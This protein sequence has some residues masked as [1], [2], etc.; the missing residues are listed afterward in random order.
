[1]FY[2]KVI[3]GRG[4]MKPKYLNNLIED[5]YSIFTR[6]KSGVRTAGL[7]ALLVATVGIGYAGSKSQDDFKKE[8]LL[9]K[10]PISL[11]EK[12]YQQSKIAFGSDRDGN[13]EIYIINSDGTGL[14]RLTNNP[15][16]DYHAS[17]SPDGK[18][19][20]FNS[21]RD[22][23]HEIYV[24]NSD[25]TEQKNLTNNPATDFFPSWSPDGKKIAF[26][27]NRGG[28]F[29]GIYGNSE[30][31]VM[32]SDGTEQKRLTNNPAED[33]FASW[34][35]DG[36]KIAFNSEGDVTKVDFSS[37]E[38]VN[39]EIYVINVDG[40]EQRRL[41]LDGRPSW[42]PDGKKIAFSPF[43]SN[44]D[45]NGEI[46][47]INV[48]GTEQKRLT[49]NPAEDY[50]ASWS[51]DGKKI[52]FWSDRD[53]NDEIYVMNSDGTEQKNLTK[54]P[55]RDFNPFWSP[56]GKK[57]AF[58]SNRD[59][60]FREIYVMNS[61]GSQQ[62]RLTNNPALDTFSSWSPYLPFKLEMQKKK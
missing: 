48:D 53:G 62:T 27:S 59:G 11:E 46:Y 9:P 19:I 44:R 25:G 12:T 17:W 3:I 42:S 45:V 5:S 22:G 6:I 24:M 18:K 2:S 30:I 61:D 60:D 55:A 56:D 37:G 36:K 50:F 1:M 47:V 31:Y 29:R 16:W 26:S 34:S 10:N 32:N 33:Y 21:S 14:K 28:N 40:T 39:L 23:N 35:P 13:D 49:N 51:P 58:N 57:I 7:A 15:A 41:A 20:A 8:D 43:R 54:N 38:D 4:K 52:A